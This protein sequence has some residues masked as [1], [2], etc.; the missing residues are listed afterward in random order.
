MAAREVIHFQS[1]SQLASRSLFPLSSLLSRSQSLLPSGAA[2]MSG[3][4]GRTLPTA[5]PY[6][7]PNTFHTTDR[8][9]AFPPQVTEEIQ[10]QKAHLYEAILLVNRGVDEAVRGLERLKRAKDSQARFCVLRRRTHPFR[11]PSRAAQFLCLQ[12]AS[13]L[14]VAGFGPLRSPLQRIREAHP[15]RSAGLSG[16]ADRRRSP[17]HGGKAA[18]GAVLHGGRA[19]GMGTP[20]PKAA[21]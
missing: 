10:M 21:R 2:L 18:Q 15:R 9:A 6:V 7:C 12:C 1:S 19:A 20:V 14:G 3:E 8:T 17:A 11:G 4:P 16:R 13:T 5:S